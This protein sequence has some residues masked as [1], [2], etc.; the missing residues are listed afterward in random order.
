MSINAFV[1]GIITSNNMCQ[2]ETDSVCAAFGVTSEAAFLRLLCLVVL[3]MFSVPVVTRLAI[4]QC[5]PELSRKA[6]LVAACHSK[7]VNGDLPNLH[8]HL[9]SL[10]H[11]LEGGAS[12]WCQTRVA[13]PQRRHAWCNTTSATHTPSMASRLPTICKRPVLP[14]PALPCLLLPCP[15]IPCPALPCP[16]L[17]CPALP[18]PAPPSL[19]LRCPALPCSALPCPALPCSAL[20]CRALPCPAQPGPAPAV[21]SSA[22][23]AGCVCIR[24]TCMRKVADSGVM[25]MQYD[26][27]VYVVVTCLNPLRVYL[28]EEGLVRFASERFSLHKSKLR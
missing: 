15:N 25:Y 2:T 19:L 28:Y 23:P 14:C 17:P 1:R 10:W 6:L 9:C 7:S 4:A 8:C 18:C 11:H 21:P 13:S 24:T 22:L 16:A 26:L 5:R 20:P 12:S 27:R 3:A